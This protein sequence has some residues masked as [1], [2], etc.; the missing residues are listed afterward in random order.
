[1]NAIDR[2]K[3]LIRSL[4]LAGGSLLPFANSARA[5]PPPE[6]SRIRIAK[7]PA[8]CLAPEYLAEEMLKLKGFTQ[9]EYP[10]LNRLDTQSLL[11]EDVAI[12]Q[13]ARPQ[14]YYPCGIQVRAKVS[15]H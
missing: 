4:A 10:E 7:I 9:I 8:I 12:F 13:L 3:F 6:V 2:R 5:E 15:L 14:T 1:M 11:L